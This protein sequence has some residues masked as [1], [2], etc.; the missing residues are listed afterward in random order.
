MENNEIKKRL[1]YYTTWDHGIENIEKMKI[2]ISDIQNLN[3]PNEFLGV[4]S[5]D[6]KLYQKFIE[7]K[8]RI[9]KTIGIVCF[10]E[11]YDN[12]LMW[13][14]YSGNHHGI[15]LGF[16]IKVSK[17][18]LFKVEYGADKIVVSKSV[19]KTKETLNK[20]MET[21]LNY[22]HDYWSYENEYRYF[23]KKNIESWDYKKD[24]YFD[25]FSD[26]LQLQEI[27][28]GIRSPKNTDYINKMLCKIDFPNEIEINKLRESKN[29]FNFEKSG[30]YSRVYSLDYK[31][32]LDLEI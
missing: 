5:K 14:H 18:S 8:N 9:S 22:K 31:N 19:F 6:E 24:L 25:S 10:S 32:E 2:K 17:D 26:N 12:P 11:D 4:Q 29:K 1:Y 15:C 30:S 3:D 16:D 28:L 13:G 20:F 23:S 21:V 7:H 27:I